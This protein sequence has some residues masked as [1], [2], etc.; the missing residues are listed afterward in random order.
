VASASSAQPPLTYMTYITGLT[1]TPYAWV[2]LL[3]GSSPVKLG[4][5]VEARISPD[6]SQVAAVSIDKGQAG[7]P[8]TLTLY[9]TSGGVSVDVTKNAQFMQLLG[10]SPDSKLILLTVG[11]QLDVV[12]VANQTM[13]MIA[14]GSIYGASF[15]PGKSEQI[16]YARSAPNK[17]AVNLYVTDA[18]V[19]ATREITHDGLSELPLWGPHGIAYSHEKPRAKNPYPAL[20]LW[21]INPDGSGARQ[22]TSLPVPANL[23]GLTP[24]PGGFSA[25]GKHLLANYV[26]PPGS[27]H[28]EAYTVDLSG[29]KPVIRDLTGD[30]DGNIGE[31]ISA[32]GLWILVTKG[33]TDNLSSL[34]IEAIPWSGAKPTTVIK[35]GAYASWNR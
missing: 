31:A 2:S 5:A 32:S 30:G 9:P 6:G 19:S 18:T 8:S 1:S 22:L 11:A 33:S 29:R 16:V 28:T 35:Q 15:A 20:Q 17:T 4:P 23:E 24:V 10:W 13:R 26:G 27:N 14:T 7:K 21:M 25:N 3:N 12:D 34:S